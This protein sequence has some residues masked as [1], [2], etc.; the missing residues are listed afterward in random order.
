MLEFV[1]DISDLLDFINDMED[2]NVFFLIVGF[3]ELV[4]DEEFFLESEYVFDEK[5][6][7]LVVEDFLIEKIELEEKVEEMF[8]KGKFNVQIL[9]VGVL[10]IINV[11]NSFVCGLQFDCRVGYLIL[12]YFFFEIMDFVCKEGDNQ[13]VILCF[14]VFKDI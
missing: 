4:K 10:Q 2:E 14:C 8:L 6:E 7:M 5:E 12:Q 1:L 9:V 13:Y 3:D 11:V